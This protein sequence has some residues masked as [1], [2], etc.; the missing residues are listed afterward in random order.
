VSARRLLSPAGPLAELQ[1][2][3]DHAWPEVGLLLSLAIENRGP[4]R[5][6]GAFGVGGLI[7]TL[8]SGAEVFVGAERLS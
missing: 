6:A 2:I 8:S 4:A 5:R 1:P 7:D 3:A